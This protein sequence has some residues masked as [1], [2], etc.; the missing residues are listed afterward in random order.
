MDV[1]GDILA[2][3]ETA[4][5]ERGKRFGW[6]D[7]GDDSDAMILSSTF[8]RA[9]ARAVSSNTDGDR[10]DEESSPGGREPEG[11]RKGENDATPCTARAAGS[12]LALPNLF[13]TAAFT[14][15]SN[16][17]CSAVIS[18][19]IFSRCCS[20]CR[21]CSSNANS[22]RNWFRCSA[23]VLRNSLDVF[24]TD[25][26]EAREKT[27]ESVEW[28]GPEYVSLDTLALLRARAGWDERRS[29]K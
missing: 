12:L 25:I 26:V 6:C 11:N 27:R 9:A 22:R 15:A 28:S 2:G 21:C 24:S 7:C 8:S 17:S 13:L 29:D 5:E 14:C 19:S 23:H 4:A 20:S 10:S 3:K 1:V 16:A 18:S